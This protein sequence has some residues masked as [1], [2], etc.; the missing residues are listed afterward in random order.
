MFERLTGQLFSRS[1]NR[2]DEVWRVGKARVGWLMQLFGESI[3]TMARAQDMGQ[4][5]FAALDAEI[6]WRKLPETFGLTAA[7]SIVGS[8]AIS[9]RVTRQRSRCKTPDL[10]PARRLGWRIGVTSLQSGL[11]RLTPLSSA[12]VCRAYVSNAGTSKSHP[13]MP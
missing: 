7:A 11:L 3:D 1:R 5:P 10:K 9:C 13:M 8:T 12:I 2:Q 4:D 6:G